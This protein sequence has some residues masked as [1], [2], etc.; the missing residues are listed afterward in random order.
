MQPRPGR[1]AEVPFLRNGDKIA[2]VSE[3][4]LPTSQASLAK[5]RSLCLTDDIDIA[6]VITLCPRDSKRSLVASP[7]PDAEP[8][9]AY[10]LVLLD[11]AGISQ[12]VSLRLKMG[13]S[14]ALH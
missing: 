11:M 8:V 3:L 12:V 6:N 4:H 7:I 5:L 1:F 2:Q 10:V 9:R 14:D 13:E